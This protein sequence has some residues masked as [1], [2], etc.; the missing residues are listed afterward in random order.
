MLRLFRGAVLALMMAPTAGAAQDFDAG[1]AAANAEDFATA[2]RE[3]RPLAER[4]N[5]AAQRNLGLMYNTGKGVSQDET[6]AVKWFRL[7]AEQ[8]ESSAQSNLGIMYA[9]GECVPQDYVTA[10]MWLNLA[11]ANGSDVAPKR[12][13]LVAQSMT[14]ADISEAQRRARVCIASG[15]QDCD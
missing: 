13:D 3:W 11:A 9:D 8:G 1:V 6:E 4:G 5:A 15:Y 14:P 2:L 12:R 10:H 7:A